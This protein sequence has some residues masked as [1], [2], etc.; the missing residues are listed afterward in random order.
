MKD[1][2]W[3]INQAAD[4]S[5]CSREPI[6]IPGKIQSHGVL[7]AM[8]LP[9]LLIQHASTNTENILEIPVAAL[10]GKSLS[11]VIESESYAVLSESLLN[12]HLLKENPISVQIKNRSGRLVS[13]TGIAHKNDDLI[14]L[15]LEK[16]LT[17]ITSFSSIYRKISS[18]VSIIESATDLADLCHKTALEVR[19]LTDFDRVMIY[20][21]DKD[22]N[23]QVIAEAKNA[24]L[25]PFL[26]LNY[27]ASDIPAQARELY[28]LN[29]MRMIPDV[30]AEQAEIIPNLNPETLVPLDLSFSV[31][32]GVSP[33]HIQYLKN[34]GVGAAMSI[35]IKKDGKLWGLVACQNLKARPLPYELRQGLEFLGKLFSLQI[36]SKESGENTEYKLMLKKLQPL[37]LKAMQQ[38]PVF[39]N[40]LHDSDELDFRS[41]AD[42]PGAA[43][44]YQNQIRLVGST[45]SLEQVRGLV[46]WLKRAVGQK[47]VFETDSLTKFHPEAENFKDVASGLLCISIPEPDPSYVL[48]FRP[49]EVQT[50][51]W[52]GD[53]NKPLENRDGEMVLTPR[54]SFALWKQTVRLRSLPWRPEEIEAVEELRRS[55]IEVDLERQVEAA[56]L[57]NEELDHFAY[58]VSHDLRE[59]LRGISKFTE[60][61]KK[62][63]IGTLDKESLSNLE[64]IH[65]LA[66]RAR[67]MITELHE[68]SRLGRVNLAVSPTNLNEIITEVSSRIKIL[69]KENEAE[70]RIPRL[71]PTL[72]CDRVRI[73]EAFL[74]LITN[75]IKY[76]DQKQKWVEI[77]YDDSVQPVQL[78]VR[79]NGIGI[80][81]ED[82]Q[83][84]FDIFQRLHPKGRYGDGS[85]SGLPIVKRIVERHG[86]E[87]SL[88]STLGS[89]T[90][91]NFTLEPKKRSASGQEKSDRL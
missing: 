81:T 60:F 62:D 19:E 12:P 59:P 61:I 79:D 4:I 73:G 42:A 68:F 67:N 54:S 44:C 77:G 82:Y 69:L 34:M 16:G 65:E 33:M 78:Y 80:K 2:L 9:D 83:R 70:I 51:N 30:N 39:L 56:Q 23:G 31:L 91:F 66:D 22:W 86:G 57:S 32:R 41:L 11:S 87:I 48:W 45:P 90:S 64:E 53:P 27:P 85:G 75:A 52:G 46:A 5:N 14:L 37:F 29:W 76:N 55:I 71:L 6:H 50:V 89:G 3:T 47:P 26:G 21:F 18:A 10:V 8:S 72:Q 15:E 24:A 36:S 25:E 40:G 58:I 88:R 20:R 49:E 7:L 43:I 74:N 38:A 17:E 63:T 28:R 35:S 13:F 84:I 1:T